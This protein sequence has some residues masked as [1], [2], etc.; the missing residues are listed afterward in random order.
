LRATDLLEQLAGGDGPPA[1]S[2]QRNERLH[3]ARPEMHAMVRRDAQQ[4][5][6]GSLVGNQPAIDRFLGA[7]VGTV[8]VHDVIS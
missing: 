8:P 3:R 4:R 7:I 1:A 6:L 5:L 2:H